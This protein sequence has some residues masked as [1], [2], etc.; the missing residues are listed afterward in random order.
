[1][2]SL[3]VCS[4]IFFNHESPLRSKGYV[5]KK[6]IDYIK[7]KKIKKLKLGNIDVKRDWG[8]GP[9]FVE[10]CHK[11]L[12]SKK[13]DDYVIATGK[14]LSLKKVI[15]EAFSLQ[16]L[17]YKNFIILDKAKKRKFDINQNYSDIKKI[18][19]KLNWRPKV[20]LNKIIYKMYH[21]EC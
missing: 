13:I 18:R 15:K 1:M 21:N 11:I 2:F 12:T 5:I 19:T 20:N 16:N 9:E 7:N 14:T 6:I 4:V 17:N 3:P 8:W 10:V